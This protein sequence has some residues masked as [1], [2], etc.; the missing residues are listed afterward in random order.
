MSKVAR[1]INENVPDMD[2]GIEGHTDNI[3]IRF[4]GWKSNWELSSARAMSVLH[5]LVD[6]SSV[7]PTRVTAIGAGEY[8]PMASNDTKEGRQFNRRVEVI[9]LPKTTK[10]KSGESVEGELE[11]LK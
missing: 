6:E 5:Y 4:S 7:A 8:R 9:I 10:V 1:V 2:I 11:N 3:P